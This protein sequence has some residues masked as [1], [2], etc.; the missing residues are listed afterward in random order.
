[1]SRYLSIL[2]IIKNEDYLEEFILYHYL[3][4]VEHFYIYDNE[5]DI[6]IFKR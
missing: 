6:P 5:S 3:L 2:C 1:M 4:G